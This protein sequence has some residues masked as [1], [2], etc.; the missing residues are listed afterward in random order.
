MP[1]KMDQDELRMLEALVER[2]P[3]GMDA[4]AIREGVEFEGGERTLQRRLN[5]LAEEGRIVKRGRGRGTRYFPAEGS[6]A[7]AEISS[8]EW[9]S[10]LSRE[11]KDIARLVR[12]PVSERTPVGYGLE[13]L[14]SYTPNVTMYL[15]GEARGALA[16]MGRVGLEAL[17][18]GTYL[19]QVIDRLLIDL[20]WNSSRLEGNTYSLLDTQRLLER[21]E[22]VEGKDAEETQ[23][24]L[25]HKAAIEML[26]DDAEEIG[27]NRYTVCNLHALLSEN[28]LPDPMAGGRL[29]SRP[30]GIGAS[31][32][33]PLQ[34][35]QQIEESFDLMLT[36]AEA[37]LDPFEQALFIMVHLPYLQPFDD[38]NK[39]LSRLAA[40]IPLVQ[41]N[42]CPLSFV[43]VDRE[44]Y[45]LGILG[46]YELGRIEL[47]HDVFVWAYQRSCARYSAI[48]QSLGQPDP[49]RLRYREA[50]GD[51]VREIVKTGM[52]KKQASNWIG[53]K[54]EAEIRAKDRER[55]REL[56]ETELGSL[57]E[58]NTARYRIPP[59]DFKAWMK[60]WT[61]F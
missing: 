44:V 21:G 13:L 14:Q 36:K 3:E 10:Y 41:R 42:L 55:F 27:F 19:R 54:V 6:K 9:P 2:H 8:E 46:V 43:D 30:V 18:A 33:E 28:L 49:F 32:F 47:L 7:S 48:R 20:S 16:E 17:P 57:H 11:G 52:D 60:I 22:A 53:R 58:G 37:V 50:L 25:N 23:M 4:S 34:V 5:R 35:P 39:R 15:S 38:V 31:V 1:I 45:T 12:R 24:I 51:F 40:N 61:S 26:A 59:G 29:R 56:V